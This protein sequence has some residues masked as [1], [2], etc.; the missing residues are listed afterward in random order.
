MDTFLDL[1]FHFCLELTLETWVKA[2]LT[3]SLW[4][5][6]LSHTHSLATVQYSQHSDQR[7]LLQTKSCLKYQR[8]SPYKVKGPFSTQPPFVQESRQ[9][10]HPALIRAFLRPGATAAMQCHP[11]GRTHPPPLVPPFLLA[12]NLSSKWITSTD[13]MRPKSDDAKK[14]HRWLKG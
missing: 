3:C 6:D 5:H 2:L 8:W 12:Q 13:N 4:V 10:A 1:Y 7:M 11:E 9:M 14:R